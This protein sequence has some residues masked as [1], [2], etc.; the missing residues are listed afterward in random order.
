M[1]AEGEF[2]GVRPHKHGGN[3][4]EHLKSLK[5]MG[6]E[7]PEQKNNIPTQLAYLYDT[8][9]DMR[10]SKVPKDDGFSLLAKERLTNYDV[11]FYSNNSGLD[12]ELWEINAIMSLD[13]IFER[14]T[15]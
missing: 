2:T 3:E 15:N 1:Y 13:S 6:A 10:F 5:E 14:A 8:Y 9:L 4:S 7:L 11:G 12:F